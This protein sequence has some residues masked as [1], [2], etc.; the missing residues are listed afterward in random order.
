MKRP[1][2]PLSPRFTRRT[3]SGEDRARLVCD[4][5]AFVRYENP[6]IV[7]G[8]VVTAEDGRILMCRRAIEPRHGFWTLPAGYLELEESPEEGA[9]REAWEEARARIRIDR[10]LATYTIRHLSQIQL[11]YAATLVDPAIEPGPESLECALY[12]WDDIPWDAIAF[13]S[14][15]WA[16]HHHRSGGGPFVNPEPSAPAPGMGGED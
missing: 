1:D 6:H 12:D 4:H 7:V 8:S 15:R 13:P 10:L 3:P 11:M 2:D 5:C 14:V 16:L 9:M